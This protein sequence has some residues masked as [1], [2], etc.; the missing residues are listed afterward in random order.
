[1]P[2]VVVHGVLVVGTLHYKGFLTPGAVYYLHR[3]PDNPYDPA[4]VAVVQ[5]SGD[6]RQILGHLKRDAARLLSEAIDARLSSNGKY[7]LK[8]K[9]RSPFNSG[10][11]GAAQE[12][13]VGFLIKD[14]DKVHDRAR[15]ILFDKGFRVTYSE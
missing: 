9:S 4:A 5:F 6:S 3:E 11:S 12:C 7:Y 2:K 15:G 8:P 10:R 14:D 13:T 1:M